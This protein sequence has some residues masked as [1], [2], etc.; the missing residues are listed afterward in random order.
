MSVTSATATT[1]ITLEAIRERGLRWIEQTSVAGSGTGHMRDQNLLAIQRFV[2]G[3]ERCAW[4]FPNPRDYSFD[5]VLEMISSVT[6]C[7]SDPG[8]RVGDG[9]ISPNKTLAGLE[10]AAGRIAR[11]ASSGGAFF[12]ATGHPGSMLSYYLRIAE[13]IRDLGGEIVRPAA[14]AQVSEKLYLDYVGPVAVVTNLSSLP[15][16]HGF[17][18]M[19]AVLEKRDQ[20][21]MAVCDHGFAGAA[22]EAG[23][24][25]VATMD[26]N[27]PA[28]AVWKHLGADLTIIPID[29]NETL[30]CYPPHVETIRAFAEYR[31]AGE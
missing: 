12:L 4:N 25:T 21:D 27:D 17:E 13:L 11:V 8:H 31:I 10:E 23:V 14:G 22:I 15:H 19:A 2:D 29:D 28:L 3:D 16:T 30:S 24:P 1:P 26:T 6:G 5:A 9:Y 7:S 20:I 18:Q